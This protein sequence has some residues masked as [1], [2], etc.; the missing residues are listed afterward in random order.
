MLEQFRRHNEPIVEMKKEEIKEEEPL[1]Q[2]KMQD[3]VF[4]DDAEGDFGYAQA[5][6]ALFDDLLDVGA[7]ENNVVQEEPAPVIHIESISTY[8]TE[9]YASRKHIIN[10]EPFIVVSRKGSL[11]KINESVRKRLKFKEEE[12]EIVGRSIAS[13]TVFLSNL[14]NTVEEIKAAQ[15][16]DPVSTA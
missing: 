11:K 9:K 12:E 16:V 5:E 1:V 10:K 3:D 2:K 4:L 6:P 7:N 13:A 15:Y 14:Q 8:I